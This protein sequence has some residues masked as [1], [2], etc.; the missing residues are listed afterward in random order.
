M[1]RMREYLKNKINE[2]AMNSK[3]KKIRNLYRR[4]NEFKRGLST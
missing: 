4:I 1:N 2:L 3:N